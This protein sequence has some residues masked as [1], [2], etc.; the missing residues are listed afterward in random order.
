[1]VQPRLFLPED[2]VVEYGM[3]DKSI[4]FIAQGK[5]LVRVFNNLKKK[6]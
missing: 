3:Q 2:M 6:T 1:M 4:Y 5:L